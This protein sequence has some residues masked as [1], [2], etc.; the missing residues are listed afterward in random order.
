MCGDPRNGGAGAWS[1]EAGAGGQDKDNGECGEGPTMATRPEVPSAESQPGRLR[2]SAARASPPCGL[3]LR[4]EAAA[5]AAPFSRSGRG[6]HARTSVWCS[7]FSVRPAST[8]ACTF[9][10]GKALRTPPPVRNPAGLDRRGAAELRVT[11]SRPAGL[12]A[13][14]LGRESPATASQP[15]PRLLQVVA[16][17]AR[18]QGGENC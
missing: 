5:A 1:R 12:P 7:S 14:D 6:P 2:A 4:A 11:H 10:P 18:S 9:S 17:G 3:G 15:L 8:V 16:V 13:W